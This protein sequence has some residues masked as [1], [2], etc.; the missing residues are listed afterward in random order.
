MFVTAVANKR[1]GLP[2]EFGSS[3]SLR[4]ATKSSKLCR[5]MVVISS[6][7]RAILTC[8]AF[9]AALFSAS[10]S[11]TA[12]ERKSQSKENFPRTTSAGG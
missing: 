12:R 10:S 5:M 7:T 2:S 9:V 11:G 1:F 3:A 8:N 6:A 4:C